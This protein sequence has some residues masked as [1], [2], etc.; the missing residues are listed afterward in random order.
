M[1]L[2]IVST[3]FALCAGASCQT[4][5]YVIAGA[6]TCGLV[7]ANRLTEDPNVRV[8]VIE[9]GSDERNNP[10]VTDPLKAFTALDTSID[11][12]YATTPQPGAANRTL[13]F[14]AGKG[15]GG[16]S[17]INGMTYIRGDEAQFNA[18]ELFGNEG[19]NWSA[20]FPYYKAVENFSP[21]TA[22]QAEAGATYDP[23]DHGYDGPL[24]VGFPFALSNGTFHEKAASAWNSLGY[25]EN[26]DV[27]SGNVRGFDIWPQTLNRDQNIRADAAR[28]YYYPVEDR[29]NLTVIKGTVRKMTWADRIPGEGVVVAD[30]VEYINANNKTATIH[31]SKEVI[32]SA[33]AVRSPLILERSGIGLPRFLAELG[34]RPIVDLPGVGEHMQEQPLNTVIYETSENFSSTIVPYAT[35]ATAYDLFGCETANLGASIEAKIPRWAEQVSAA[36]QEGALN[37]S[38][39]EKLFRVKHDLIFKK[40]VTI[41]ETISTGSSSNLISSL[42]LLLPFSWGSVHLKSAEAIND[43]AIDPRYFLVDFDMDVQIALARLSREFWNTEP[44]SAW[45]GEGVSTLEGNA[46]DEEWAQFIRETVSPNH[47]PIATASMMARELGGV[48]D[49]SLKVYGTRNVRVVDASVLPMQVSG[50]LTATLYA[51]AEKAAEA[52]KAA[53]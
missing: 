39:I 53:S 50:H 19:W 21:P 7:L 30:G 4:F 40:N 46:T 43:P 1:R 18:W 49:P 15:I 12:M 20:L 38:A 16:T 9:P 36:S 47:H 44:I 8:A 2:P 3:A 41:V 34:I 42:W 26:P 31:A 35:F 33:G 14:H 17:L 24:D 45:V 11:W 25:P 28:A 29:P 22:A 23:E 13:A 27:N 5:D 10:N 48:V 32:L 37:A 51:V 52:I 6:G